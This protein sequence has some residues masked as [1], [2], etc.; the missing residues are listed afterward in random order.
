MRGVVVGF[1]TIWAVTVVGWLLGRFRVLGPGAEVVLARLTF[2]VAT[3][4][5]LFAT[6]ATSTLSA[7]LSPA[8]IPFVAS[9]A[10]MAALAVLLAARVGGRGEKTV[11]ALTASYVNAANLGVPIAAYVLRDVSVIVPVLLFQVLIAAP[12]ALA[13]LDSAA[14]GGG[15][16]LRHLAL[17]PARNPIIIGSGAG[18]VCAAGGWRPPEE[19]LRPFEL[20]GSAAV[21]LALL[22]LGMALHG[23]RPFAGGDGARLRY[24][25]VGMKVAAQPLLAYAIGVMIG[26]RGAALLAAVVTSAL[27]TAQNVF[28]FATRYGRAQALARDAVVLSTLLAAPAMMRI[29][30]LLGA[31][32]A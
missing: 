3:P 28:V 23:S 29:A 6:V 32:T 14:S 1:A 19:V 4:A 5:L 21:P 24:T 20:V 9:T 25:V 2:F 22:V 17:L 8:L 31:H 10:V 30:A 18:L 26:L 16:S 15:P 12:I 13:V 7:V 27:P 11:A